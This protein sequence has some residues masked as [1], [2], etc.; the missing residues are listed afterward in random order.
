[1]GRV[2]PARPPGGRQ[3]R[4]STCGGEGGPGR[5]P[6]G[7]LRPSPHSARPRGVA[8]A[9]RPGACGFLTVQS[10]GSCQVRNRPFLR[11]P[12]SPLSAGMIAASGCS[13]CRPQGTTKIT[14][15][16]GR[17]LLVR[18]SAHTPRVSGSIS[19]R[20]TCLGCRSDP[21][22][23][24]GLCGRRPPRETCLS[25]IGVPPPSPSSFLPLSENQ[26][27]NTRGESSQLVCHTLQS[28][29]QRA[30]PRPPPTANP[31]R[32]F[33]L[34][35]LAHLGSSGGILRCPDYITAGGG[36]DSTGSSVNSCEQ[37]AA[38]PIRS[39]MWVETG[40]SQRAR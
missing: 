38:G 25:L 9:P 8:W 30:L 2:S 36:G 16:P 24:R 37:K 7:Q 10:C 28:S 3:P 1:M 17:R 35:V 6:G 4:P 31:G 22:P 18:V 32:L 12:G 23:A 34:I 11:E 5:V 13:A 29:V 14:R 27:E 20:G 39:P 26:R 40:F 21:S 19:V 15:Q 33:C